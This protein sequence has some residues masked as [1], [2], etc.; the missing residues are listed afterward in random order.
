M[1]EA[2]WRKDRGGSGRG[3]VVVRWFGWRRWS[4][5]RD[6]R[7]PVAG[8]QGSCTFTRRGGNLSHKC[9]DEMTASV[10]AHQKMGQRRSRGPAVGENSILAGSRQL[11]GVGEVE[12]NQG[13]FTDPRGSS[14]E[15][16]RWRSGLSPVSSSSRQQW[17]WQG[18][19][20][21]KENEE[22]IGAV[23]FL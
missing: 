18:V 1:R 7:R 21:G 11:R 16:G 4:T 15:D 8:F 20:T 22:A 12:E 13:V 5:V 17:R 19:C 14:V 3:S 6:F 10:D 23:D 2:R 9:I